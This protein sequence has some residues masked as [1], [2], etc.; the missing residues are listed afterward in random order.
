MEKDLC[1]QHMHFS[2]RTDDLAFFLFNFED[3]TSSDNTLDNTQKGLA[4]AATCTE[5]T[6]VCCHENGIAIACKIFNC[7]FKYFAFFELCL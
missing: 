6:K 5:Q 3:T 2:R 7:F 1:N 4:E